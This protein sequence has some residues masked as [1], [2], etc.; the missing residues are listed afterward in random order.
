MAKTIPGKI[1][2]EYLKRFPKTPNLSLA[3]K[4][5]SENK[6]SFTS[7]DSVRSLIRSYKGQMGDKCRSVCK[8]KEFFSEPGERNCFVMPESHAERYDPFII[9]Q[10]KTL[11]ISDLHF[12]YQHNKS[13]QTALEYGK[14]KEVTCILINGDLID[15]AGISRHEKD[16]RQRSVKNEFE[17]VRAFLKELRKHFPK[18][19]IVYKYGNH[20]ERWEKYLFL[21]APEIF[22]CEDFQLETILKLGELNIE[23]VKN[24]LPIKIGKLTVLHGHEMTGGSGGVNP[25]R[26]AFLKTLNSCII[27]H[28]HKTSEHTEAQFMGDII[29]VRSQGCLCGMNPHYMPINKWNLG[30]SYCELDVKTGEYELE[31]LKIIK[32]KIFK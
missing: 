31:N 20:D 22:D 2:L 32:G 15:F 5:Y 26:S 30:F 12:P 1:V 6:T 3:K 27:G 13:I 17:S 21:K 4:V 7:V 24:K 10:S 29:S 25:A 18:T 8:N 14:K 11:I 16:W 28:F 23:V 9:S 19:R